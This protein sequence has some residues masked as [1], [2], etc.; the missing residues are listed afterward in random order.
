M[1]N[2]TTKY[3][4][5]KPA[6]TDYYDIADFNA[7]ADIIDG[8]L[9]EHEQAII[10]LEI[11]GVGKS[12]YIG[13]NGNW[14]VWDNGAQDY[15]DSGI[16]AQGPAGANG[17]D[18]ELPAGGTTE[19]YLRGDK[20]WQTLNA[21]AVGLDNVT[22]ESK[23]TMF[24]GA[25][26]TGTPTAPTATAA[27]NTTQIATTAYVKSQNY[28][29]L[30]G[31]AL[32]G[33][34]TAPTAAAGTNTTQIATTAYV[35]S[36]NYAPLAGPALTGTPT[37]PTAATGTNTTQIATTAYV[38]SQN[39]APLAS[40]ALTGT[41]TAPTAASS[42]NNTQIATTAFVKAVAV[43][44]IYD[45]GSNANGAWIRFAD[46]TMIQTKTISTGNFTSLAAWGNLYY[47]DYDMGNWGTPFTTLYSAIPT[48]SG[49]ESKQ[50]TA[51][52]GDVSNTS[53]GATFRL[54]R[55]TSTNVNFTF[56]LT[57]TGIGKWK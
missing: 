24:A 8:A 37:A 11:S 22:N 18:A 33:T 30:A 27:T 29:P 51:N 42:T 23:A 12:P 17:Q 10:D 46:G 43:S 5:I 40:P 53:A 38:K 7:N 49:A 32:T 52:L 35:K 6:Q 39:Y 15:V 3:N 55:P 44:D 36:Q 48:V 25:A 4:L 26:L 21:A 34:P 54:L 14:Y 1:T 13:T 31:P 28:A 56:T 45:S 19:Q 41:P 47:R 50:I 9:S 57:V 16:A 20:T 2:Y